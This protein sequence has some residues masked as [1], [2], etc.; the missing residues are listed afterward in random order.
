MV[1]A[2]GGLF[3]FWLYYWRFGYGR[4]TAEAQ[5]DPHHLAQV[6][7]RV[8]GHLSNLAFSLLLLP[9]ARNSMW[10]AAYGIPFERAVKYHRYAL[11]GWV[12]TRSLHTHKPCV[13]SLSC[14]FPLSRL[15]LQPC[16]PPVHSAP[17][18]PS[19][20]SWVPSHTCV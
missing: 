12:R 17:P 20:G 5:L 14:F 9:A 10:V 6:W 2:V 8:F 15:P 18:S 3:A 13:P 7:A 1:A 16:F 4:I 11:P 19:P